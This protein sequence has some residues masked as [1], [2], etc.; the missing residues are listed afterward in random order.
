[1]EKKDTVT[2]SATK[3]EVYGAAGSFI[4]ASFLLAANSTFHPEAV[5]TLSARPAARTDSSIVVNMPLPYIDGLI[6]RSD[7]KEIQA[8]FLELEPQYSRTNR[9]LADL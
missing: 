4:M 3:Q 2:T 8:L 7:D 9:L 1:M 6:D 5:T